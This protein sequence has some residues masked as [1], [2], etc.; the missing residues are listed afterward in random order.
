MDVNLSEDADQQRITLILGSEGEWRDII[1]GERFEFN[2]IPWRISSEPTGF[3]V[4]NCTGL[5]NDVEY[6]AFDVDCDQKQS[7][8]CQDIEVGMCLDIFSQLYLFYFKV[9]Y[10]L[11]GLCPGSV[12]DR[13]YRLVTSDQSV[14]RMFYG[15]SGKFCSS[16]DLSFPN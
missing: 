8:V 7:T 11:R 1:T 4:E 2:S 3:V 15:P 13:Q 16:E 12:L 14:R 10:Q 9:Y 5:T 6:W